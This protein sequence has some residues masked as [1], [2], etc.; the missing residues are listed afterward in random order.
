MS[1]S[2]SPAQAPL[3][4]SYTPSSPV[5]TPSSPAYTPSSPAY[6]PSSPAYG[7][8]TGEDSSKTKIK[9]PLLPTPDSSHSQVPKHHFYKPTSAQ[10]ENTATGP[11]VKNNVISPQGIPMVSY[12]TFEARLPVHPDHSGFIIGA[13][14]ATIRGVGSKHKVDARMHNSKNGQWP[15][16]MIR[17]KMENVEA[18]FLEVF[19]IANIANS[20]IPRV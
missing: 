4:P 10:I 5:Y 20:K 2:T 1:S 9:V 13:K 16:I 8:F 3:S 6:T 12:L 17:G 19:S 15:Y 7:S 18:A 11:K 14:G